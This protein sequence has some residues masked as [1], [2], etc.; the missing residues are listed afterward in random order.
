MEAQYRKE[1]G[2]TSIP[3]VV[4]D[5]GEVNWLVSDVIRMEVPVP[6]IAQSIMQLFLSRDNR[7]QWA[8]AIAMMRRGFGGHPYG[9][10]PSVAE[11]EKDGTGRRFF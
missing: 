8:R 3:P 9:R 6:V 5:T 10:D 2:L 4:E 7:K 11:V 1:E